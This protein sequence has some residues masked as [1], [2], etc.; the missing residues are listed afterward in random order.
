MNLI[1]DKD[2]VDIILPPVKGDDGVNVNLDFNFSEK[3][4][5]DLDNREITWNLKFRNG[6]TD[7]GSAK[8]SA[9]QFLADGIERRTIALR[10]LE[11]Y[12]KQRGKK[13]SYDLA[14]TIVDTVATECDKQWGAVSGKPVLFIEK[15]DLLNIPAS[16]REGV[17]AFLKKITQKIFGIKSKPQEIPE[18]DLIVTPIGDDISMQLIHG[19]LSR[20][21]KVIPPKK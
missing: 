11:I 9:Y 12:P 15:K 2:G 5:H 21:A 4:L 20:S 18:H 14:Q 6:K 3:L 8:F 10:F 13:K 19:H 16:Q 17:F 1:Y 7:I